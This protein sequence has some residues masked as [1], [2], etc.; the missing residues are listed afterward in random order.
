[1]IKSSNGFPVFSCDMC[2]GEESKLPIQ[3]RDQG[4]GHEGFTGHEPTEQGSGGRKGR[5]EQAK[6]L[7]PK[8]KVPSMC[9]PEGPPGEGEMGDGAESGPAR[10]A[11]VLGG[12]EALGLL[13]RL[14]VQ[15]LSSLH[16]QG[17]W[18]SLRI[19]TES[20]WERVEQLLKDW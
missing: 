20:K 13:Q 10:V 4:R 8:W 12:W 14:T 1:M 3:S 17:G 7:I 19:V 11:Q 6:R 16:L 9:G 15:A 5:N 2:H 18:R